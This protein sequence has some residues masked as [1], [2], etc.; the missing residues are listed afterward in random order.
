MKIDEFVKTI[1]DGD[2]VLFYFAG[3]GQQ[4]G[5]ENYLLPSDYHYNHF[6]HESDYIVSHAINV[7]YIIDEIDSKKG[8]ITIY[9]F[10]CCRLK[11]KMRTRGTD[12]NQGLGPIPIKLQTLVVFA[13]APNEAVLDET[14]NNRNGSLMENLLKHITTP[15]KDIEEIMKKV[16]VA[17][18]RQTG[19]IQL[20]YRTSSLID[21]VCLVTKNGERLQPYKCDLKRVKVL[22]IYVYEDDDN[23]QQPIAKIKLEMNAD[24]HDLLAALSGTSG[25]QYPYLSVA[26][27][28]LEFSKEDQSIISAVCRARY[29]S[30]KF[31]DTPIC[32][33]RHKTE[34]KK[35]EKQKLTFEDPKL[36][37]QQLSRSGKVTSFSL[38]APLIEEK[39]INVGNLIFTFSESSVNEDI[40]F[41]VTTLF[42]SDP[43][44]LG[45]SGCICLFKTEIYSDISN[46]IELPAVLLINEPHACLYT[47]A[48]PTSCWFT[49]TTHRTRLPIIGGIHALIR[50]VEIIP[51]H[52]TLPADMFIAAAL[53]QPL[54]ERN[55]PVLCTCLLLRK[56]NTS[57]FPLIGYHGTN[58]NAIHSILLDGLVVPGTVVSSGKRIQ[59]PHNH[60]TRNLRVFGVHDYSGAIFLSPSIHHSLDPAFTE[61]FSHGD[62]QLMPVLECSVKRDS[63]GTYPG[64]VPTYTAHPG[65]DMKALDW[66]LKDPANIEI[67]AVLFIKKIH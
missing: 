1:Q 16:T 61:I 39:S 19:G 60:I 36:C 56:R 49:S 11:T 57:T 55:D 63:Y 7:K 53:G 10:D 3:H 64:T 2:L 20:P 67:N 24:Y 22:D 31:I 27:R 46:L 54:T 41:E 15:D 42:P 45:L 34:P 58:I 4:S 6:G 59:P 32:L 21:D 52:L 40:E 50:H 62:Q 38:Q 65:D 25:N 33:I 5:D 14:W 28:A 29:T 26:R 18:N 8:R 12:A 30:S 23:T 13:C 47:L 48:T 66:R 9:L 35:T 44:S 37:I 51:N 43:G 17:V